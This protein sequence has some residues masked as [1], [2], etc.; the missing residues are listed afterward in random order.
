MPQAAHLLDE[1]LKSIL[2]I[3][4]NIRPD[5]LEEVQARL[6]LRRAKAL[7]E[8]EVDLKNEANVDM[9]VIVPDQVGQ[10]A[11]LERYL[12]DAQDR[13]IIRAGIPAMALPDDYKKYQGSGNGYYEALDF[14]QNKLSD[15]NFI[16]S[17]PHLRSLK[18][19]PRIMFV[20]HEKKKIEHVLD[21]TRLDIAITN[22]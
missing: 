17:N 12:K 2:E 3:S 11:E 5:S 19:E 7:R 10:E 18:H 20:F 4:S 9:I 21:A 8:K 22:G 6:A 13:K 14:V 15:A 16:R 1:E